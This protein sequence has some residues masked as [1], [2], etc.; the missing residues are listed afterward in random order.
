MKSGSQ[1]DFEIMEDVASLDDRGAVEVDKWVIK[2]N[3]FGGEADR[4]DMDR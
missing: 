1:K 3:Y 4:L 2:R